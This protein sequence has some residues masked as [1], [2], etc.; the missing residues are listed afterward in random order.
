M[1]EVKRRSHGRRIVDEACLQIVYVSF[2]TLSGFCCRNDLEQI[3]KF[4]MLDCNT[5]VHAVT[6]YL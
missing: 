3:F 1:K 4:F 6:V 2:W 5:C